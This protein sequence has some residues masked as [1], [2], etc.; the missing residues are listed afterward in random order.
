MSE[1]NTC[2][3]CANRRRSYFGCNV[4]YCALD[5]R[6]ATA[7]MCCGSYNRSPGP[8]EYAVAAGAMV[9]NKYTYDYGV[10]KEEIP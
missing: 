8:D 3:T 1:L 2:M 6:K 9:R 10:Y 4:D 7:N 5:G